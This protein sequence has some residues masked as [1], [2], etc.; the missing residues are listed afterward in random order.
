MFLFRPAP[1]PVDWLEANIRI[2]REMSPRRPGPFRA[3]PYQREPLNCW[4]PESGVSDVIFSGGAQITKTLL[5]VLGLSYRIKWRPLPALYVMPSQDMADKAIAME[6]IQPLVRANA[7]LHEL[8]P[9]GGV[10]SLSE[11][12]FEGMELSMAGANSPTGLAGRTKGLIAID[13]AAKIEHHKRKDS[14]E[15]HPIKLATE[16]AKDLKGL[17]FRWMCSTPNSDAHPFWLEWERGDQRL[18]RVP[19]PNCGAPMAFDWEQNEQTGYQS[20]VWPESCRA[21][22]G[23]WVES[24]VRE[25]ARYIC[26]S[27][28]YPVRNEE[29]AAMIEAGVWEASVEGEESSFRSYLLTSFYSSQS[30]WGDCAVEY[31]KG[32]D[33]FGLQNFSNSWRARPFSEVKVNVRKEAVEKCRAD[34]YRKGQVRGDVDFLVATCDPGQ[35]KDHWE[36]SAVW[37]NGDVGPVLWGSSLGFGE[38]E[39]LPREIDGKPVLAGLIDCRYNTEEVLRFCWGSRGFWWPTMGQEASTGTWNQRKVQAYPGLVIYNY[40]DYNLKFETYARMISGEVLPLELATELEQGQ[41]RFWLPADADQELVNHHSGQQLMEDKGKSTRRWKRL[42]NDHWGDCSKLAV[43]ARMI[44]ETRRREEAQ[45]AAA[46]AA[47]PSVVEPGPETGKRNR[48]G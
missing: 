11:M 39:K 28:E 26:P 25:A 24:K 33:L 41:R 40:S 3:D 37:K 21:E 9:P 12:Q 47:I 19:C 29:K 30:T 17:S 1:M 13:E 31:L 8:R 7:I 23:V 20:I 44:I 18:F 43:L 48:V 34:W 2:P 42:P 27:C 14:T 22:S 16:R 45:R 15:A 46:L 38:L 36:I 5:A 10:F 4:H 6:K 35:K 32:Q